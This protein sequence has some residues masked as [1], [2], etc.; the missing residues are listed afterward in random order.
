MN[1]SVR[2]FDFFAGLVALREE[3]VLARFRGRSPAGR[4]ARQEGRG[5]HQE[6]TSNFREEFRRTNGGRVDFGRYQFPDPLATSCARYGGNGFD[7]RQSRRR[8]PQIR[9]S[10]DDLSR[11]CPLARGCEAMGGGTPPLGGRTRAAG[12]YCRTIA[13]C[14]R[15][16]R[17]RITTASCSTVNRGSCRALSARARGTAWQVH[18]SS[19]LFASPLRIFRCRRRR[20]TS[21]DI[22]RATSRVGTSFGNNAGVG[23]AHIVDHPL[24]LEREIGP[25]Y[26][27]RKRS[28]DSGRGESAGAVARAH[29]RTGRFHKMAIHAAMIDRMDREIGRV[30]DQVR[31]WFSFCPTM[32]RALRSWCGAMAMILRPRPPPPV[33]CVWARAGRARRTRR[34]VGT[35]PG[36]T[37]GVLPRP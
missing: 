32:G 10:R 2:E 19:S 1:P 35:R 8:E 4:E 25:P 21:P 22:R 24:S 6:Q 15:L 34:S 30:L 18:R 5:W 23:C 36:S 12:T 28:S 11:F 29:D 37:R 14:W 20:G 17:R 27:F 33:I 9:R 7:G 26:H 31:P 3:R 13:S 16:R